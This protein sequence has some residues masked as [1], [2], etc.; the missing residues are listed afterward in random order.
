MK[1]KKQNKISEYREEK[2]L[3]SLAIAGVASSGNKKNQKQIRMREE[4][5]RLHSDVASRKSSES[6][7]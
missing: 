2:S 7:V 5:Q 3:S 6:T 1:K 4:N